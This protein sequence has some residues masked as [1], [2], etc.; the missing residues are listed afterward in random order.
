MRIGE[1]AERAGV[2][3]RSLRYYEEQQ[4]L[5]PA[6]TTG[7]QRRYDEDAVER[8]ALIQLL[9]QAGVGSRDVAAILPCVYS[10]TT[11]LDMVER[12]VVERA[13]IDRQARELSATRDRLDDV[14][15]Q[16]RERLVD[17]VGEGARAG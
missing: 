4:L 15:V 5:V 3:V 16:A 11:S 7:G 17:P 1:L 8:V 12:L 13:R 9:F 10:G 2:S 14:I 6:R